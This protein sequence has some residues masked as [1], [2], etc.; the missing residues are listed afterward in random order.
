MVVLT[1]NILK[2]AHN[3]IGALEYL[4]YH[5]QDR[6]TAGSFKIMVYGE[7]GTK[8]DPSATRATD[9]RASLLM[10]FRV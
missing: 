3:I 1:K 7:G 5:F 8:G 4:G 9:V 2:G 6:K 10:S